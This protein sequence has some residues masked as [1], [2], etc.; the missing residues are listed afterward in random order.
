M[1]EKK[2]TSSGGRSITFSLTKE[3]EKDYLEFKERIK[4][5]EFVWNRHSWGNEHFTRFL[6]EANRDL[7]EAGGVE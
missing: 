1:L 2:K 6:E 4:G 3:N 7:D 5:T